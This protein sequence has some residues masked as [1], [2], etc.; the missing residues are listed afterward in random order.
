ME[1]YNPLK[2]PNPEEWLALSELER[3]DLVEHY[4]RRKRI[5]M[6]SVK[7]HA[8]FH[9]TVENQIAMGDEPVKRK[10]EQ[11]IGEGLDRHDAIHAIA[12]ILSKQ[13]YRILKYKQ[14]SDWSKS[15]YAA[16]EDLTAENWL[17]SNEE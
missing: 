9:V 3:I 15:Y 4:H 17:R 2:A 11:L 6:P 12:W 5:R 1:R 16:L 10:L 13:V 7:A 14:S 8:A